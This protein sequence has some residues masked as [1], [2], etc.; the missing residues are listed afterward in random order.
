MRIGKRSNIFKVKKGN[1]QVWIQYDKLY[2]ICDVS[3]PVR[4]KPLPNLSPKPEKVAEYDEAM[5]VY[6]ASL[7]QAKAF[8]ADFLNTFRGQQI[9]DDLVVYRVEHYLSMCYEN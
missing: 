5:K 2:R 7:E 8:R 1:V 4:K 9:N 6:Q 3:F